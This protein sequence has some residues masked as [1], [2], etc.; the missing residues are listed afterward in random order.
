[1]SI[2]LTADLIEG[3][4]GAFLSARYDDAKPTPEL[5]RKCWRLYTS[6]VKQAG[7]VAPRGHAKST[8]LTYDYIMAE[9]C[10][11]TAS[12]VILI[13]STEDKAAEQLSNISEELHTN[14]DLK[15]EFGIVGFESDTKTE[16][17]VVCDDGHRFRIVARGAEQKIR[18]AMW[19]GKRPDLIVCDDME[20]DE[21]V[22]NRDRR[23]KFR[24]WFFRAAKQSLSKSGRIR[25]H[26]TILHDDSL[27]SRLLKN[28]AWKFLF[29]KAHQS[30]S[31]FSNLLWPEQWSA[32]DLRKIQIEFEEDGDSGGYSQEYLN[33]PLDNADAYLKKDWFLPM[34]EEDFEKPKKYYAGADFA[35]SKL[36]LA[37]R[38][39]F[40]AGAKDVNNQI[41]VEGQVKGR[42]DTAEWIDELFDFYERWKPELFF[43]EGGVIWLSVYP[44][45]VKEMQERD[46]FINFEIRQPIKDKAT[47]GRPLQ[48]RMKVGNVRFDKQADWYPDFEQELIKFTG[49]AQA[50][51]DDQFDSCAILV[52]GM[53]A[54]PN[55]E[56]DDF[57]DEEEI[58]VNYFNRHMRQASANRTSTGY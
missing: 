36:D 38:T 52:A 27:L 25:V 34:R 8:A 15:V 22:E 13:G 3:F 56:E 9:V 7:A 14:Q 42:W 10:F 4:A 50:T 20:D 33:T 17:I 2:K 18:G 51:L 11:R 26:G 55:L 1:M 58:E 30:Y 16:I 32:E 45:I 12:Y 46:V 54:I 44:M 43:V 39:S 53:E 19:N 6:D 57:E 41:T 40:T 49:G 24:R 37:N 35:V 31:D 28:K 47:R 23:A 21:Q 29:F 5:H 48:K